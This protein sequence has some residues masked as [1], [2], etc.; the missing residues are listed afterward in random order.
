MVVIKRLSLLGI[1]C[2]KGY[3][4]ILK[5]CLVEVL[6]E[7]WFAISGDI[8]DSNKMVLRRY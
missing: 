7:Q 1:R 6:S 2:Y 5:M 3:F 8:S 4:N